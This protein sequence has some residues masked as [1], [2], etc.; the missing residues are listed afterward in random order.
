MMKAERQELILKRVADSGRVVVT[1]LA[2]EM[3]VTETTLR[4]DLRNWTTGARAARARRRDQA[5]HGTE[6]FETDVDLA[7]TSKAAQ[8]ELAMDEICEN[9]VI[10]IDGGS[11]NYLAAQAFPRD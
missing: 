7:R 6:P 4:K 2:K 10:F 3:G 11:T 5:G 1:D 9:R 8:R